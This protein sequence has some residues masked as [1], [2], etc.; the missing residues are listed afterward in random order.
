MPLLIIK[1]VHMTMIG[2]NVAFV[3]SDAYKK[4]QNRTYK[5]VSV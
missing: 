1:V 3:C 5:G 2:R 4:P